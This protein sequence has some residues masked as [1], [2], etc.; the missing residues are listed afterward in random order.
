MAVSKLIEAAQWWAERGVPVFPCKADKSPLTSNGFYDAVIEPNKVRELFEFYGQE[1]VM[2][3]GRM[4]KDA[5]MFAVDID[6]YKPG[7]EAWYKARLASGELTE[8]RVHSTKSGGIHLLY[9]S[10]EFP[11][12]APHEG[13][14]VKGEGGYI[15]LPG[16]PG[17]TVVTEGIAEAP[18]GLL[19]YLRTA[20]TQSTLV[21]NQQLEADVLAARGFH[22]PLTQLAARLAA[23]G[24]SLVDI[25]AHLMKLMQASIA[26]SPQ[27]DRHSRWSSMMRGNELVRIAESAI[28]K[29]GTSQQLA[30]IETDIPKEVW[31]DFELAAESLFP[32]FTGEAPTPEWTPQTGKWPYDGYFAHAEHDLAEQNFYAYPIIAESETVVM[33]AEPKAGKTAI[34]LTL[35]LNLA[36]GFDWGEFKITEPGPSL[37]FAMEGTRAVK[38]RIAAWRKYQREEGVE[39]PKDLP[40]YVAEGASAFYKEDA[41]RDHVK[42][43]VYHNKLCLEV[44]GHPLKLIVIDTLTR[45]MTGGDQNSAEDTAQLFDIVPLLRAAGIKANV[46]FIHHKARGAGNARGSSNIE[47]EPDVLLDV[48]KDN[49]TVKMKVA[50]ARSIEDGMVYTFKLTGVEL[51]V[52]NQGHPLAGVLPIWVHGQETVSDLALTLLEADKERFEPREV[53]SYM[54]DAGVLASMPSRVN[55][56]VTEALV[57]ALG[58]KSVNIHNVNLEVEVNNRGVLSGLRV[59]VLS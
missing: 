19:E 41:K 31:A 28:K 49:D 47:A 52:N 36:C 56:E 45:A 11:N 53:M 13:V 43:I 12:V 58:G 54:I 46:L 10:T 50:R 57:T 33:F 37:Y 23:A 22:E 29:F 4:G 17:Y 48:S 42:K 2:I 25:Q 14:E 15:V 16:S 26:S 55:K 20:K 3:G 21:G 18:K 35:A 6:L 24:K 32:G 44:Y 38:L 1:A 27:H 51:G 40:L 5:G 7:A 59:R 34:A 8:T 9:I 30:E 39:L